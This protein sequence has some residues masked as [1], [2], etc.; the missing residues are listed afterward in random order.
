M[1][2]TLLTGNSILFIEGKIIDILNEVKRRLNTIDIDFLPESGVVE[3][4]I[5]DSPLSPFPQ[6][7]SAKNKKSTIVK[8]KKR[9]FL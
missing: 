5:E 4:W 2:D 1:I 3:Q 9:C 8:Q 7:G 6:V